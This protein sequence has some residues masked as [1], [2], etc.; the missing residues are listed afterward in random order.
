MM[1]QQ[2]KLRFSRVVTYTKSNS[3]AQMFTEAKPDTVWKQIHDQSMTED[4][5]HH[6]LKAL[7]ELQYSNELLTAFVSI[8][9]YQ[10][11]A[12]NYY[13]CRMKLVWRPRQPVLNSFTFPKNYPLL[14][15][16]NYFIKGMVESG[17]LVN[18]KRKWKMLYE[19]EKCDSSGVNKKIS[20]HKIFPLLFPLLGCGVLASFIILLFEKLS[21][22]SI[23]NHF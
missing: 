16:F 9:D 15:Y 6:G 22:S 2:S 8:H 18:I 4:S 14:P 3:Y 7:E 23:G 17:T 13:K 20:I 11:Y 19:K 1:Y 21:K 5:F 10:Y 12:R